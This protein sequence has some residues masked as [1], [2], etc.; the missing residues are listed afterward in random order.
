MNSNKLHEMDVNFS[1]VHKL[2]L[3]NPGVGFKL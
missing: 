1:Y 3:R 2:T